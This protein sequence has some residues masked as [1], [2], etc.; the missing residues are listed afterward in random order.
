MNSPRMPKEPMAL[1]ASEGVP[2]NRHSRTSVSSNWENIQCRI[3]SCN[4]LGERNGIA[5]T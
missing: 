1:S 2:S 4:L 5:D 3:S